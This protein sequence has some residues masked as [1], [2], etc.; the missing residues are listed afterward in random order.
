MPKIVIR[1]S[2][3]SLP[4]ERAASVSLSRPT[5]ASLSP[6]RQ[7]LPPSQPRLR[8]VPEIELITPRR[9][10]RL[11]PVRPEPVKAEVSPNKVET[12]AKPRLSPV[13]VLPKPNARPSHKKKPT[14]GPKR[15]PR[16]YVSVV[17]P[18]RKRRRAD[19]ILKGIYVPFRDDGSDDE[20]KTKRN[21]QSG[22]RPKVPVPRGSHART[23]RPQAPEII[24]SRFVTRGIETELEERYRD[25]L[26]ESTILKRT[27]EQECGWKGCDAVLASEW[28]LQ[29]H[30]ESRRHAAQGIF[31][32]GVRLVCYLIGDM[33][34]SDLRR[35]DTLSMPLG[36]L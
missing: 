15:F 21:G 6:A 5:R 8:R 20:S 24:V 23:A 10:L 22:L 9:Y 18:I 17:I 19:L 30:V 36:R 2:R 13:K 27:S 7:S 32:A 25:V 26:C 34:M 31:K 1:Q 35:D 4:S 28:Q 14:A 11:S 12:R 3:H 33:L 16:K 29:R